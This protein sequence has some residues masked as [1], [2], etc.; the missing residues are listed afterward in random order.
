MDGQTDIQTDV[1][2]KLHPLLILFLLKLTY[3][4]YRFLW[5]TYHRG[6]KPYGVTQFYL[7][8]DTSE[9]A[10]HKAITLAKQVDWYSTTTGTMESLTIS[11]EA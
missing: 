7:P 3:G 5:K 9:R 11:A 8:S 1:L 4:V 6:M 10:P 2:T